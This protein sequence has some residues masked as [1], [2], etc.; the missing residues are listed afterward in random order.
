ML[1]TGP[2]SDGPCDGPYGCGHLLSKHY[3]DAMNTVRCMV[4]IRGTSTATPGVAWHKDCDCE[5]HVSARASQAKRGG[6]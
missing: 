4:V 6:A 2:V 1:G 3:V 5:D